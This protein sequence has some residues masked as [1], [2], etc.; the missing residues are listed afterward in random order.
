[1]IKLIL[2]VALSLACAAQITPLNPVNLP[3]GKVNLIADNGQFLKVC[4]GC[5]GAWPDSASIQPG[6][7]K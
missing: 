3:A 7:G 1:M 2:L 5:G 4:Q 6:T